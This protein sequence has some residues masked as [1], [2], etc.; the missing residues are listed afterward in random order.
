VLSTHLGAPKYRAKQIRKWVYEK[1]AAS[2]GEMADLPKDL[3]TSLDGLLTFG[4]MEVATE[5]VR[6]LPVGIKASQE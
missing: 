6:C 4:C 5:Q 3:R 2:F 1:G